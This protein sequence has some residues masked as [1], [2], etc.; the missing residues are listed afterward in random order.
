MDIIKV[1][2]GDA[3]ERSAALG[4]PVVTLSY[5]QSLDGCLTTERGVRLR[6]SGAES[7]R[8]T[9]RLRA[10]HDA[11]LVGI[12]TLLADDP[13]LTARLVGGPHPQPVVLDGALRTPPECALL[14][15]EDRKPWI[16]HSPHAPVERQRRLEEM[17]ARLI[18]ITEEDDHFL[19]LKILLACLYELGCHSLMVEGGA[20][21]ITR[22]LTRRLADQ[23]AI[24]IAP[25]WVGGLPALETRP[26][27]GTGLLAMPDAVME[28]HGRDLVVWG[29]IGEVSYETQDAVFHSTGTGRGPG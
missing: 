4:R 29:R 19:D 27:W 5:A 26:S 13:S 6:L 9:H 12:G 18:P 2:L 7:Q 1:L 3:R 24:I 8:L 28:R 23:A 25:V 14:K 16:A 11:I 21:V 17:G 20:R 15:R 22:F 10:A